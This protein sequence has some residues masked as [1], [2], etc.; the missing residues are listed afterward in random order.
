MADYY[1]TLGVDRNASSEEIKKAY[2]RLAREF[3]PDANPDKP[4]AEERFKEVVTAYETLSDDKARANYDRYGES[5][6]PFGDGANMGGFG[7]IFEQFFGGQ[8][9]FGSGFGTQ[10]TR[11][12]RGADLETVI[13]VSF[14]EAVLG[15]EHEVEVRTHVACESCEATGQ[16]AKSKVVGCHTCN[17]SG[18]VRQVRQSILGQMVTSAQCSACSGRG[19]I[20]ESPCGDCSG[21]GRL[22]KERTYSID[23]PA[24]VDSGATLRLSGRGAA[25]VRGAGFGDLYVHIRVHE[26]ERFTRDGLN[27]HVE[28]VVPMTVAALGGKIEIET[29]VGKETIDIPPGTQTDSTFKIKGQGVP[30]VQGSRRGDIIV[31]VFVAVPEDLSSEQSDLLRKFAEMRGDEVGD[32]KSFFGRLRSKLG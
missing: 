25:G 28:Y 26:H 17:G 9:P 19:E 2:R 18:Q 29:L 8:S 32:S 21:E 1:E 30:A 7:D 22:V 10:Q 12:S 6:S 14:E 3:H 4:D 15:A 27:L 24:G 13:D 5:G 20:I 11:P 31:S 16:T 23:I